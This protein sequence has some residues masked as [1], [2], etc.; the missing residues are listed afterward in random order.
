MTHTAYNT[1]NRT[2]IQTSDPRNVVVLLYEGAIRFLHQALEAL[3]KDERTEMSHFLIKTQKIIHYMNTSLDYEN[4]GEISENLGRLYNY[5][6]DSLNDANT[7]CDAAK[8]DE[9]I[10]LLRPLL[11]AWREIAKDPV[12]AAALEARANGAPRPAAAPLPSA[13]MASPVPLAAAEIPVAPV[14]ASATAPTY[15]PPPRPAVSPAPAKAIAIPVAKKIDQSAAG[16]AAY[17]MR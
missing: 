17:G 8:I 5:M 6:R 14:P 13:Q 16:R 12:A 9:V 15:T 10:G 3:N 1:Y 4:G 11:E 2:E 7:R